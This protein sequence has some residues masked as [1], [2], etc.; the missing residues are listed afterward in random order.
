MVE[1]KHIGVV[2]PNPGIAPDIVGAPASIPG[3]N[4]GKAKTEMTGTPA[5]TA[6]VPPPVSSELKGSAGYVPVAGNTNNDEPTTATIEK[7]ANHVV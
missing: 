6:T 4:D 2:A 5:T 3:G 7:S 1:Q